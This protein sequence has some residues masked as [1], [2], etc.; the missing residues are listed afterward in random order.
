MLIKHLHLFARRCRR[1]QHRR[2]EIGEASVI[3]VDQKPLMLV[4]NINELLTEKGGRA[5]EKEKNERKR[6]KEQKNKSANA[7]MGD[8]PSRERE[9]LTSLEP[10]LKR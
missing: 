6:A 4:P 3:S 9:T 2:L 7:F 1:S 8:L 10:I 5:E